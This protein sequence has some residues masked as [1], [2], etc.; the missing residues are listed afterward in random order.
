MLSGETILIG[1][2]L[3]DHLAQPGWAPVELRYAV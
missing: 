1:A 3:V 2:T